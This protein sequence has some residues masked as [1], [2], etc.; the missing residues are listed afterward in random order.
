M[1]TVEKGYSLH[2]HEWVVGSQDFSPD[3]GVLAVAAFLLA[4]VPEHRP[5]VPQLQRLG[6]P[7]E[8]VFDV[9][10]DY[11][12]RALRAERHFPAGLVPEDEHLLADHVRGFAHASDKKLG[13]LEDRGPHLGVVVAAEKVAGGVFDPT[14]HPRPLVRLP[15]AGINV[16]RAAGPAV[17]HEV[18]GGRYGLLSSSSAA[19][20]TGPWPA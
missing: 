13:L 4:F 6:A 9:R 1:D 8:P 7:V 10:A 2:V 3:L 20:S 14:P 12:R 19:E 5:H 15:A 18:T 17:A 11:A 16:V